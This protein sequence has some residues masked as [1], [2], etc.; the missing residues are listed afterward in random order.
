MNCCPLPLPDH[1]LSPLLKIKNGIKWHWAL[2]CS[3]CEHQIKR[4]KTETEWKMCPVIQCTSR[5]V[6]PFLRRHE[7]KTFNLQLGALS[8]QADLSLYCLKHNTIQDM[9]WQV[10]HVCHHAKKNAQLNKHWWTT[11]KKEQTWSINP[12]TKGVCKFS[13]GMLVRKYLPLERNYRTDRSTAES[14]NKRARLLFF[15]SSPALQS[16]SLTLSE[17][18]H[19]CSAHNSKGGENRGQLK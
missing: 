6:W 14:Q 3:G 17:Y 15:F 8:I 10:K 11:E 1:N 12:K 13:L 19:E 5:L 9:W 16:P 4:P 2:S 7:V 18:L